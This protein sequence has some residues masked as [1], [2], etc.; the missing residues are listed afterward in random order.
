MVGLLD[1]AGFDPMTA[2]GMQLQGL[3][4]GLTALGAG[5]AQA[6]APRP[7]GQP[8]P[9]VGDAFLQFGRGRQ[10]G[11]QNARDARNAAGLAAWDEALAPGADP[12]KLSPTAAALRGAVPESMRPVLGS[13]PDDVRTQVMTQLLTRKTNPKDN[14]QVVGRFIYDVSSGTPRVVSEAPDTVSAERHAQIL[15]ER[16]AGRASQNVR[17][18]QGPQVGTIP[19]GYQLERTQEGAWRMAP[20][21][22]GPVAIELG[23][24]AEKQEKSR[25]GDVTKGNV[26]LQDIDRGI[27]LLDTS[28]LPVAGFGSETMLKFGGSAATNLKSLVDTVRSNVG[29]AQLNQMRQESPT[30]GALGQVTERELAFLQSVLGSLDQSQSPAQLRD[31]MVRLRN[32]FLDIVH[33]PGQG[34]ERGVPSFQQ[35]AP[36]GRGTIEPP[37]VAPGATMRWNPATGRVEPVR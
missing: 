13:L 34:P 29:F 21:P 18:E 3:L 11:M 14:L 35:P 9:S 7:V 10:M 25:Q 24:K 8:G 6:G 27:A 4:G 16:A 17:V 28:R 31:N 33:G 37:Q 12:A 23:E 20:I 2:K 32:T 26:V 5:L 36:G 22:G 19:Q 30:G 15:R 1:W